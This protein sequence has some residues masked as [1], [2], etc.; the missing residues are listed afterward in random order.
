MST[1]IHDYLSLRFSEAGDVAKDAVS[2]SFETQFSIFSNEVQKGYYACYIPA[3]NIYY[4]ACSHEDINILA[5]GL[6]QSFLQHGLKQIGLDGF[7]QKLKALQFYPPEGL[8]RTFKKNNP[9]PKF[10]KKL[11]KL[12]YNYKNYNKSTLSISKALSK[13]A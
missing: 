6:V 12:P 5:D 7:Y 10:T 9:T 11:I 3:F 2:V 13:A 4:T 8:W 1:N